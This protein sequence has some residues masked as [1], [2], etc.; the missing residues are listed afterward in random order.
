[1]IVLTTAFHAVPI[2][3]AAGYSDSIRCHLVSKNKLS[4]MWN[5]YDYL[6]EKKNYD[7]RSIGLN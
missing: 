6:T 7:T 5:S 4:R 2:S 1:M 3:H